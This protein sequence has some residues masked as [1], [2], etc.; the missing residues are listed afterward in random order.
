MIYQ[1]KNLLRENNSHNEGNG[2]IPQW[3]KFHGRKKILATG[4]EFSK[5]EKNSRNKKD[6]LED[7]KKKI[8]HCG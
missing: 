6:F 2:F 3:N 4:E 5:H 8:S 1:K 7:E